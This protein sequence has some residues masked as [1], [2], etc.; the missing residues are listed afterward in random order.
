MFHAEKS[1]QVILIL[2]VSPVLVAR[3]KSFWSHFQK[4][5]TEMQSMK[6][7]SISQRVKPSTLFLNR[8][9]WCSALFKRESEYTWLF[10]IESTCTTTFMFKC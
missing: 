2:K 4:V 9:N 5:V 6:S 10:H 1:K 3:I 7:D 8:V